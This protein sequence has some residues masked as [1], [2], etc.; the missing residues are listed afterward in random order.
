MASLFGGSETVDVMTKG[1]KHLLNQMTNLLGSKIGR[2]FDTYEGVV[3]PGASSAQ[4]AAFGMA[5]N[6][7]GRSVPG[8]DSAIADMIA[9]RSATGY[10][11]QDYYGSA[12]INPARQAFQDEL[13][14][15]EARYGGTHGTSGAFADALGQG[16][17]RFGV[18]IG[19]T[20]ANLAR[21]ERNMADQRRL[22]G[23]QASFGQTNDAA[24][25]M[26]TLLGVG[27]AQRGIEAQRNLED[28]NRWQQKQG[29]N[30]P[31]F[32]LLGPVLGTQAFG[33]GQ[34]QGII[35]GIA[36]GLGGLAAGAGMYFG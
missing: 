20:M 25:R 28:M 6:M 1:Q 32:G 18:G 29:Y 33:I 26:A 12:V 10:N 11:P 24:T 36:G 19:E 3:T 27:G 5:P 31:W 30:N 7:M 23:I 8:I 35:P 34:Q 17:A 15:I 2:P 21:D 13:R 22:G 16:A 9:G 4:Q 14:G